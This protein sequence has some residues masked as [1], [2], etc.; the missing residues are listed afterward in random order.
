MGYKWDP[1]R[2][3]LMLNIG[4][5]NFS[6]KVRGKKYEDARGVIPEKLTRR[7]CLGKISEIFDPRG[8]AVPITSGF[9][10]D[11]RGLNHLNWGEEIPVSLRECWE[12]NFTAIQRLRN[13][14]FKRAVVPENA[15]DLD[16]E[17]ID[18]ADA[19]QVLICAAVYARFK[20]KGGGYSCQLVFARSKLVPEDMDLPRAELLACKL[21]ATL[22]HVVKLSFGDYHK[23]HVKVTDSQ[24]A[25]HW[26][27]TTKSE[28]KVWV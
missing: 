18:V 3:V 17:T 2:D 4:D 10:I 22:G 7:Q 5:F 11:L 14:Y 13:I 23:N 12:S 8:F 28:L 19:S 21:N 16:I 26:I 1:E 25:L 9:K 27:H 20:L 15:A 24:V 6:R